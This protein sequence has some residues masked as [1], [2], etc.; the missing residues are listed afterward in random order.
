MLSG[1]NKQ[2]P[3]CLILISDFNAKLSKWCPSDKVN[4]AEED[5]DTF[6]T[7]NDGST[8]AYHKRLDFKC[9][10]LFLPIIAS[11]FLMLE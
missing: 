10:D 4:K 8:E 6:T 1:I 7:T 2:Q 9:I 3:T 11:C 5:T